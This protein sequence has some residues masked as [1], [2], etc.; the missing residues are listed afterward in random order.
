MREDIATVKAQDPAARSVLEILTCYPGLRALWSHRLAHRL[1]K[2][3]FHLVARYLSERSRRRTGIEIHP[4]AVIG[5]RVFIDHGTGVVIGETAEVGDDVLLYQ[6]V[7]LGGTGK[8]KGKRHPTLEDHVVVSTGA[9]IL[10]NIRIGSYA[11]IG[12]GAVVVKP[13]PAHTTVVGVPG[14]EVRRHGVKLDPLAH[15]N[16]PD[17]VLEAITKLTAEVRNLEDRLAELETKKEDRT[18]A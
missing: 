8:E 18:S 7:T 3:G 6:G 10:G 13:V 1:W 15:G 11:K 9:K 4:A 16:L 17:P 2:S 14:R 5:R 12:A